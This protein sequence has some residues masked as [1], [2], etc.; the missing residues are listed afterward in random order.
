MK[1]TLTMKVTH[2]TQI[3]LSDR[4]M[5]KKP[6]LEER[7]FM[8]TRSAYKE[9]CR[10]AAHYRMSPSVY[11]ECLALRHSVQQAGELKEA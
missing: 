1:D 4:A 5:S 10:A 2:M 9:L 7:S 3:A 8:L 6:K 11:L